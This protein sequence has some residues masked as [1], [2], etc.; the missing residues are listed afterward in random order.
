MNK[1]TGYQY[2]DQP[3]AK[4]LEKLPNNLQIDL[5][6]IFKD[7]HAVGKSEGYSEGKQHSTDIK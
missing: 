3:A 5:E 2:I 4:L 7:I 6:K 1:I